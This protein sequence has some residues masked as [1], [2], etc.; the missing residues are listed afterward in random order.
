MLYLYTSVDFC[1]DG[2]EQART[3]CC[4][5]RIFIPSGVQYTITSVVFKGLQGSHP[6][7]R[8]YITRDSA[9]E[10]RPFFFFF[11]NSPRK[12]KTKKTKKTVLSFVTLDIAEAGRR[13]YWN[14]TLEVGL[15]ASLKDFPLKT[16]A[17]DQQNYTD[18]FKNLECSCYVPKSN[19]T[20][21]IL[22]ISYC[23]CILCSMLKYGTKY[24]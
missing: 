11:W 13:F 16:A 4:A 6:D 8:V 14:Y 19:I 20:S 1:P 23:K 24:V 18:I 22:T 7:P 10:V 15:Y 3:T 12:K 2:F 21:Y 17:G 5:V 9:E